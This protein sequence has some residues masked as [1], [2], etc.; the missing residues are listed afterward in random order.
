[1][2]HKLFTFISEADA[3]A[4]AEEVENIS[5]KRICAFSSIIYHV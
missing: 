2:I 3:F 4:A 1:M 5:A